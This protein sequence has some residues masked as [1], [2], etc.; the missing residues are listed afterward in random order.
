MVQF[1]SHRCSQPVGWCKVHVP[2]CTPVDAAIGRGVGVSALNYCTVRCT[3]SLSSAWHCKQI[4]WPRHTSGD[5]DRTYPLPSSST[6][7]SATP[8]CLAHSY[9]AIR[10]FRHQHSYTENH[11][12]AFEIKIVTSQSRIRVVLRAGPQDTHSA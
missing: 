9:R 4:K 7:S 12:R 5:P 10:P 1:V 8:F 2:T 6:L 3:T 11:P